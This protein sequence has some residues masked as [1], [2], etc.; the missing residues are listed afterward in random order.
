MSI[1]GPENICRHDDE[2]EGRARRDQ[3]DDVGRGIEV[4]D[5]VMAGGAFELRADFAERAGHRT[6]RNDLE[7]GG[8]QVSHGRH[9]Q[10]KAQH[11]GDSERKPFHG[12]PV[13]R[14]A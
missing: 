12:I 6:A 8:L 11:R 7:F 3:L 14:H 10:R 1:D 5:E 4:N 2:V 13:D 9:D